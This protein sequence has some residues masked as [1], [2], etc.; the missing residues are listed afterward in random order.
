VA[1]VSRLRR[2]T[3]AL[4]RALL[5]STIGLLV[6]AG[7]ANAAERGALLRIAGSDSMELVVRALAT[8]YRVGDPGFLYELDARGSGTAPPLL[9]RGQ[10][11][12]AALTRE[13]TALELR[14][15]E[16][17][18][19]RA[20]ARFA[21]GVDAIAVVVS[22]ANP[23]ERLSLS[24]LDAI[25]SAERRCGSRGASIRRWGDAGVGPF[26]EEQIAVLVPPRTSGTRE[27]FEQRA[28]CGGPFVES[29]RQQPGARSILRALVDDPHGISFMSRSA[30]E[31]GVT[32]V[33]LEGRFG[34]LYSAGS[35]GDVRSGKYPLTRSIYLYVT[36][37]ASGA[38]TAESA[39]FVAFVLSERGQ[40]IVAEQGFLA[41]PPE[42]AAAERRALD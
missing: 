15:F 24:Q 28:L 26:A 42:A 33:P 22:K 9:L 25:F 41:L 7:A 19:G 16:A 35:E 38:I 2:P 5:L 10:V 23:L 31:E 36:R 8:E 32:A 12:V 11:Q 29:A 1:V 40:R 18:Y 30:V 21:I 20:P 37:D 14:A 6:A 17:R 27:Y 34:R 39:Q 4:G 13:L 3:L